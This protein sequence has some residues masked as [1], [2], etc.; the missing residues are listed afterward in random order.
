MGCRQVGVP[1]CVAGRSAGD[2]QRWYG[3]RLVVRD[4]AWAAQTITTQG[5]AREPVDR[6]IG[7]LT[8]MWGEG[9]V[10]TKH[11]DSL[12]VVDRSNNDRP[13]GDRSGDRSKH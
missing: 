13:I 12:I 7:R 9:A 1:R 3:V 11:G 4:T 5:E 2:L 8:G 10:V 6:M